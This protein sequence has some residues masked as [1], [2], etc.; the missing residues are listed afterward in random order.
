LP[1]PLRDYIYE[2]NRGR[3]GDP[4]VPSFEKLSE[5]KPIEQIIESSSR[6]N[7]NI[8]NLLSG[9]ENWLRGQ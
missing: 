4:L 1:H 2:V 9:F 5:T 8:D 7:P 3:Y 6:S